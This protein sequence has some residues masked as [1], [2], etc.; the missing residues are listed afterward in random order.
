[1]TLQHVASVPRREDDF[2]IIV[3]QHQG[4]CHLHLPKG[5]FACPTQVGRLTITHAIFTFTMQKSRILPD[6][7]L[8]LYFIPHPA[9]L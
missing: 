6:L 5:G 9:G 3:H 8:P 2:G 7:D 4:E 1:M